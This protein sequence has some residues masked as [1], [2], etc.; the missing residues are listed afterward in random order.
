[1]TRVE[2]TSG[3]LAPAEREALARDLSKVLPYP[4]EAQR[5]FLGLVDEDITEYKGLRVPAQQD[6]LERKARIARLA[7][8]AGDFAKA[9]A[10]LDED[11]GELIE[12]SIWAA[13]GKGPEIPYFEVAREAGVMA[14]R[15]SKGARHWLEHDSASGGI[16]TRAAL[17]G[18]V[19]ELGRSY[20]A[21]F[22]ER[23]SP[24]LNG[25]YPISQNEINSDNGLDRRQTVPRQRG[26]CGGN[27]FLSAILK[28]HS[29]VNARKK[30]ILKRGAGFGQVSH[31]SL[32]TVS[33]DTPVKRMCGSRFYQS[34]VR[35]PFDISSR[36]H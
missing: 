3:V 30:P 21:A 29:V 25:R 35:S 14:A 26:R 18:L 10:D 12:Q 24:I 36:A 8:V 32:R 5:V 16:R 17:D 33:C 19:G 20:L 11:S 23:P 22:H 1:M 9:V 7:K 2:W 34:S 27:V 6:A 28:T 15:V 31:K 4:K 13:E